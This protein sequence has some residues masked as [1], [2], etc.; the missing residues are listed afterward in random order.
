MNSQ[1]S[2]NLNFPFYTWPTS[3]LR[4]SVPEEW[5]PPVGNNSLP[6]TENAAFYTLT[7]R[8]PCLVGCIPKPCYN[9][10]ETLNALTPGL[11]MFTPACR[12]LL[13][14]LVHA[15]Q[16][17]FTWR[18][19]QQG[20]TGAED[21]DSVTASRPSLLCS[22]FSVWFPQAA[23]KQGLLHMIHCYRFNASSG[24]LSPITGLSGKHSF[25]LWVYLASLTLCLSGGD[26]EKE[27]DDRFLWES[28]NQG[29]RYG[30]WYMQ[31]LPYTLLF[32][33]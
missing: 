33:K 32:Y 9:C 3:A 17:P 30:N 4:R 29:V 26:G 19:F 6:G 16:V 8:W 7:C 15:F 22:P 21:Q 27:G 2:E 13:R 10:F 1:L 14:M 5:M 11:P 23:K 24:V 12:R 31:R 28:V 25:A 20:A 18:D